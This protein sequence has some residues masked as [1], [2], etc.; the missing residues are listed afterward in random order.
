M[1]PSQSGP[2][3]VQSHYVW[4]YRL[5][6]IQSVRPC[7]EMRLFNNRFIPQPLFNN[8]AVLA[9]SPMCGQAHAG[10][11]GLRVKCNGS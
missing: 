3:F 8:C 7:M 4:L 10:L 1:K 11:W 5:P 9:C 2:V 6:S